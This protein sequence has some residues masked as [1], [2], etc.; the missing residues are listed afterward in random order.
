MNNTFD[1]CRFVMGA[2]VGDQQYSRVN[3]TNKK[4]GRK[5]AADMA[6]RSLIASGQYNIEKTSTVRKL[7][8]KVDQLI[9]FS[10][11]LYI[12]IS[13]QLFMQSEY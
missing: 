9:F 13:G 6:L 5:E 3:C 7:N 4:D 8:S 2:F 10:F 12:V 1:Y 11:L